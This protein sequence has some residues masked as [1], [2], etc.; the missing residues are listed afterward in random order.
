[1]EKKLKESNTILKGSN[2][3]DINLV[4]ALMAM[5]FN[6][7]SGAVRHGS[8]VTRVYIMDAKSVCGTYSSAELMKAWWKGEEWI[9][10]NNTHPFAYLMRAM[11]CRKTLLDGIKQDLPLERISCEDSHAFIKPN[12]SPETEAKLLKGLSA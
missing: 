4:S 5:G 9:Q 3:S 1:M 11:M 7:D 12:C 2:T 6:G 8:G 10:E